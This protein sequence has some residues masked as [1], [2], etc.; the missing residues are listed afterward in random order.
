MFTKIRMKNFKAWG[1]SLAEDGVPLGKITLLLGTNSSGKTSLLQ[2][3]RLLQQTVTGPDPDLQLNLGGESTD[4]VNLGSWS[5]VIHEHQDSSHLHLGFDLEVG[6][7]TTSVDLEYKLDTAKRV[8][9]ERLEYRR[10]DAVYS[11]ARQ[12]GGGYLLRAP[13]YTPPHRA[14]SDTYDAKRSYGPIRSITMSP[15]AQLTLGPTHAAAIHEMSQA[16]YRRFERIAYLGPLRPA[17]IRTHQWNQQRPGSLGPDGAGAIKALLASANDRKSKGQLVNDVG[18]WLAKM[19]VADALRVV[20][21]GNSSH[22]EVRVLRDG[23]DCNLLDVGFGV[24]QVLP[25]L[26]LAYFVPRNSTVIVEEPEIHLHPLA[27]S[28]LA[29]LFMEVS[30]SRNIQFLIETHS[31]H[32]FR[33]LQ[34]LI[35]DEQLGPRDCRL[36]FVGRDE[37]KNADLRSLELD[38]FGRVSNWPKHFFG[39]SVGET[40]RQMRRMVDRLRLSR[41]GGGNA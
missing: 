35:A 30:R 21:L 4:L 23:L 12:G 26:T 32:I 36:Y 9:V 13:D 24:S 40:E 29:E 22:Y 31:E 20:Q 2:P 7:G 33:R 39:D 38:E 27:Q 37:N 6:K 14:N 34:F 1:D 10:G 17:P 11:A 19:G 41:P 16:I 3:F 8:V 18:A 15:E 25:V 28:L 5:E